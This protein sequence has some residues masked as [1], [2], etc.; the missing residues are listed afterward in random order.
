MATIIRIPDVG[1]VTV[2]GNDISVERARSMAIAMD[3]A[4]V[5]TANGRFAENAPN[6]DRVI[7]FE[8]ASGGDKGGR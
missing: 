3:Y 7:V 2:P 5:E 6:G 4:Q 8:R 1:D